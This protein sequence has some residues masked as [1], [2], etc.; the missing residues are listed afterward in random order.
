M[1]EY[2]EITRRFSSNHITISY[3]IITK[4]TI[5][6]AIVT[7]AAFFPFTLFLGTILFFITIHGKMELTIIKCIGISA[8]QLASCL[9]FSTVL[10]GAVYLTILDGL[11]VISVNKIKLIESNITKQKQLEEEMTVTNQ[12]IWFRDALKT[13]SYI[14]YAKSFIELQ[15]KL[16]NV[17]FFEFDN[18]NNLLKS[19]YSDTAEISENLWKLTN[20]KII[21]ITGIEK[22][23]SV[24]EVPTTLS[25]K[26]INKMTMNPKSISFWSISKYVK[27][28]DEVGLSSIK[29]KISWF[30]RL[31]SIFQMIAFVLLTT[32]FC[33]NYNSRNTSRYTMKMATL[34]VMAFPI[35]FTNNV[36]VAFGE[37]GSIP[38]WIAAFCIPSFIT[39]ACSFNLLTK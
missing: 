25:F 3:G 38:I 13:K 37:N 11:S 39:I 16:L 31:S 23:K 2:M 12:G 14:V 33:V 22:T 34:L 9:L 30:A 15:K 28:L 10:M 32:V 29:Y 19:I 6:N 4:L 24:V 36:L 21:D 18:Q 26:N 1:L 17:K 27:V 35:H 20:A 7:I 8:C 5:L